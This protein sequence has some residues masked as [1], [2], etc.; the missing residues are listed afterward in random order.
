MIPLLRRYFMMAKNC[1]PCIISALL[2]LGLLIISVAF[3]RYNTNQQKTDPNSL[4]VKNRPGDA[5]SEK[6]MYKKLTTA[7]KNVIIYKATEPPF[8]GKFNKHFV[9]GIYT[10]KQCSAQLF[11]SAAKFHSEC[12]WP[13]FDDQIPGA[14]KMVPDAD[15]LRTEIICAKCNGHL[16]HIFI[17]E[18]LT[19]K[20][21]RYCVN[22][23]SID[24]TPE[25]SE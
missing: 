13:S 15:G 23:L 21:T 25:K 4:T 6:T 11:H 3:S 14:V 9:P 20:N 5:K 16:G 10:C 24:F 18:Q 19:S 8:T 7:E 12:G 2:L 1:P 22:S 17:G